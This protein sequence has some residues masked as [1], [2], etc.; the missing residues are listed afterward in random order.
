MLR[1]QAVALESDSS[2]HFWGL[3]VLSLKVQVA[4][5]RKRT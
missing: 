5:I 3:N 2:V 4:N 1:R